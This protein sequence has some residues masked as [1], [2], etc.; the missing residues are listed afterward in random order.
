MGYCNGQ[1]TGLQDASY[2]AEQLSGKS[3][4]LALRP[5]D[6]QDIEEAIL[7]VQGFIIDAH[8]PPVRQA[9]CVSISDSRRSPFSHVY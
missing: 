5:I 1:V 8:L 4:L 3:C 9:E 2:V 7:R 6:V